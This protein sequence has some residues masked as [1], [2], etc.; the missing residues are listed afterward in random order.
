MVSGKEKRKFL[1]DNIAMQGEFA[2]TFYNSRAAGPRLCCCNISGSI[3][4]CSDESEKKNLN[5]LV[6]L[7]LLKQL[8]FIES[9]KMH[10]MPSQGQGK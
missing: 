10:L 8:W 4:H 7:G 3:S 5:I 6:S 2:A 1:G 9:T